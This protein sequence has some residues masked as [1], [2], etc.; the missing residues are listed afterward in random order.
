MDSWPVTDV[1]GEPEHESMR[2]TVASPSSLAPSQFRLLFVGTSEAAFS[3]LRELLLQE[4][5]SRLQL[6]HAADTEDAIHRNG[7][8]PYDLLLCDYEARDGKGLR[9]LHE[10]R[11]R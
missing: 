7:Q 10:V 2:E 5:N 6:D 11:K 9:L 1:T 3:H 4:C 8:L